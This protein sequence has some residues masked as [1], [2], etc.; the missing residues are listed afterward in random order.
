MYAKNSEEQQRW[1]RALKQAADAYVVEDFFEIGEPLG[2]GKFS[3]V[4]HAINKKTKEECAVKII[5]RKSLSAREN[6]A[7][8]TE[9]A[10]LRLLNHPHIIKIEHVFETI[11]AESKDA[12]MDA[13]V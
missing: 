6:Q 7:L 1:I 10:V 3:T 11:I 13:S 12:S 9:I 2:S 4:R 5:Q 8:R